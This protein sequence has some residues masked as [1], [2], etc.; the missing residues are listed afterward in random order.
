MEM[1][2]RIKVVGSVEEWMGEG[3]LYGCVERCRIEGIEGG[4]LDGRKGEWRAG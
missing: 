2:G 1:E 3:L 4:K